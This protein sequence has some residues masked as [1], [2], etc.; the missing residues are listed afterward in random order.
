LV[1]EFSF[2]CDPACAGQARTWLEGSLLSALGGDP[3]GASVV[4]DAVTIASELVT[5]AIQAECGHGTLG[6][7]FQ[8]GELALLVDDDAPGWPTLLHPG[9]TDTHGRGLHIVRSL[10]ADIGACTV[11]SGKQV[12]ATLTLP[13]SFAG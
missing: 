8:R 4:N 5:N 1:G 2:G 3:A 11:R 9:P 13:S 6:W 10:A 7:Q 12:W